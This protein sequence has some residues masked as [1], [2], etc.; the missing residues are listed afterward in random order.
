MIGDGCHVGHVN[1]HPSHRQRSSHCNGARPRLA[2]H[3]S[4]HAEDSGGGVE[5]EAEVEL[6]L[7]VIR[8]VESEVEV[9]GQP[10]F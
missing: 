5:A 3:V 6:E 7:E 1:S 9:V 2:L 4:C 8:E 10:P